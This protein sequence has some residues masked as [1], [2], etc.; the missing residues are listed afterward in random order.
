MSNVELQGGTMGHLGRA[1]RIALT[2]SA[3][4]TLVLASAVSA[5]QAGSYANAGST[6]VFDGFKGNQGIRTDPATVVGIGYVHASQMDVGAVGGDFVAVGTANG[7]GAGNCADDY[8]AKWTIYVD[9]RLGGIYGCADAALD[10][11]SAGANP[12]FD[13]SWSWCSALNRSTWIMKFDGVQRRCLTSASTVGSR[14]IGLLETTGGGT[15]DRNIDVKFTN[16]MK[17]YGSGATWYPY[18]TGIQ[19]VA[20]N[21]TYQTVSSTAFNV[22]LAPLD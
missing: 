1:L 22:Y 14:A 9:W 18:G 11:Y 19:V 12:S 16:L 21:Y 5:E 6:S 3:Y 4:L 10:V 7:L 15:T 20:P 17:N 8:D 2:W 13:I